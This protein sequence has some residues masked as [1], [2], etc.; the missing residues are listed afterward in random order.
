MMTA[1]LALT[2]YTSCQDDIDAPAIDVPHATLKANTTIADIKAKY[3]NSADNYI[4][5]IRVAENDEHVVI[6]GRVISSDASGN[7]YKSLVIQDATGAL[8]MSINANSLY[9]EFRIGQEVVIDLTDMYIGKYSTLEQLGYPDYTPSYGW[10]ATFMPLEFFKQHA[11]L[12]GLPDPSKIDTL[13]ITYDDLGNGAEVQ[14]KYQSQLVRFNNVYFVDGGVKSFCDGHKI[15][16]NRTLKFADG[17][18]ADSIIV[19]TSGYANYW[20]MKLPA[21]KGDIVGILSTYKQS[22]VL[23]WQLLLRS[24][25]DLLNFGNPTLPKGTKENPY[26]IL[27]AIESADAG[28]PVKA[29]Y[30]GYIV[31][32]VMAG[33]NVIT[34]PDQIIWGTDAELNNTLVIGQTP[35]SK[36]LDD[37]MVVVLPTGSDLQTYGNLLDHPENY[38]QQ[39]WL[40]A[41]P[42]TQMGTHALLDNSGSSNEWRINGVN[43]GGSDGQPVAEGNGAEATPY[44]PTQVLAMGKSVSETGKWVSGYIVGFVPDKTLSEAVFTVPAT[45][46][47]NILLATTPDEKDYTKCLPIQLPAAQS[48]LRS[49]LNLMDNP[50]NLNQLCSVYGN[51]TAYF[52]VAGVKETSN[53]KLNGQQGG[54]DTPQPGDALFSET[55]K[56]SQGQFVIHNVSIP[57]DLS[58]VWKHDAS[59]GYMK[60]SAFAN[61]QSYASDSWLMSPILDLSAAQN[62]VLVFY[63]V[64]NKFPS[65]DVAKQQVSLAVSVDGGN[66]Q[67]LNIPTWS[68]NTNW[69]F[70]SSGNID[71][72]AYVGK[73]IKLG[74]HYTSQD[75]TSGT[76]EIKNIA[77]NGS[78]TITATD[79][80]AFPG[81][82]SQGGQDPGPNPPVTGSNTA[83]LNAL[84]AKSSYG[85]YTTPAGWVATNCNIQSGGDTDSNPTFKFIGGSDVRAVCLNGKVS[86]PGSLVS[87]TLSGGLSKLNFNYGFAYTDSKCKFTVNIKKNGTVVQTKTID[88]T[89]ITKFE[90]LSFS[91]DVSVSGDFVIEIV[92][93]CVGNETSNKERVS[94]WNISWDN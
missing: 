15:N 39:I 30:T 94:I 93:D 11:Q 53:Y 64:C 21:E 22:G 18:A 54:G 31:G 34:S 37:C 62:P 23:I 67:T 2:G 47:A 36:S 80:S 65:I 78:G 7:I 85:T 57:S 48:A 49:A 91:W 60:A 59:Y 4:D 27:E 45:N 24:P 19:R 68:T 88:L 58:Y 14:Q 28:K 83:D 20:S 29:W 51:L 13:T 92:N 70:V 17:N 73:K 89:S 25:D 75:G 46:A 71:L 76:W 32:S 12:N 81:G 87:P 42:G 56:E 43:I 26:D 40:N 77:I 84:T 86:T 50:G 79:D 69:T 35:E 3:W 6:A 41:T 8:A 33:E 1:A 61:N 38:L 63:H 74:F 55:F 5:T 90:V 82:G 52:G 10:Q 66:W 16:T 72:S 9:N 44:N